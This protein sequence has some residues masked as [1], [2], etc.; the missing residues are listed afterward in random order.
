LLS[1]QGNMNHDLAIYIND[2]L[3]GSVAAVTLIDDLLA[4]DIDASLKTVLTRIKREIGEEQEILRKLLES[5]SIKEDSAKKAMAWLAEKLGRLKLGGRG[6]D[7]N[8]L[9]V[10]QVLEVL[11]LGITGKLLGWDVLDAVYGPRLS[12]SGINIQ[13][14]QT[15]ALAQRDA[16]EEHRLDYARKAF[17]KAAFS[18]T[19]DA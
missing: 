7:G 4:G 1:K 11:Y 17:A 14:L 2:H 12:E 9:P 13:A 6:A 18:P 8:C 10:V 5:A 3:A 19:E 15:R 16:V